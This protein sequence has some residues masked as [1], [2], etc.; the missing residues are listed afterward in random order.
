M[1]NT[2]RRQHPKSRA[3]YGRYLRTATWL[4]ILG[5][6]AMAMPL[7]AVADKDPGKDYALIYCTVWGADNRPVRGIQVKIQKV[8]DKKLKWERVSDARGEF[9]VRVPPAAGDYVI[10]AEVK[11]KKGKSRVETKA[12]VEGS[13]RVDVALRLTE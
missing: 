7:V 1:T 10:F 3:S 13:E 6:V 2:D 12:H 5:L 9:A 11:T 4:A 8:G